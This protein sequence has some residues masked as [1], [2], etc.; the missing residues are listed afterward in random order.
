[1]RPGDILAQLL[2]HILR[3]EAAMAHKPIAQLADTLEGVSVG[4][5][6]ILHLRG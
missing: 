2:A 1:M 4:A 5:I 3:V 6:V